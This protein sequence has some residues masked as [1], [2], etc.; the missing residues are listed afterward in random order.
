MLLPKDSQARPTLLVLREIFRFAPYFLFVPI[1]AVVGAKVAKGRLRPAYAARC[2]LFLAAVLA[3][4]PGLAVNA[5]LKTYSHRPRPLQ[6]IEAGG[7]GSPFRP[8]FRFDG[9]CQRNCSFSSGE[10]ASAF[11]T[12]APALL[13]PP[14]FT[15]A[16]T[17][18]ALGFGVLVS[19][20]RMV[21]GAHFL[22]DVA[23]SALLVLSLT[24]L[25]RRLI[26]RD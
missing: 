22:S 16:A 2:A 5:G 8:F 9:A 17:A 21:L 10:A 3:L 7:G 24:L 4:G 18:A 1:I 13:A 15:V 26:L 6:T 25:M 12:V 20:M 11:W 14:P 23:F 19:T